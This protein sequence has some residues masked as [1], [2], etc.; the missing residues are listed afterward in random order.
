MSLNYFKVHS[1]FLT[2]YL[3]LVLGSYRFLVN[4]YRNVVLYVASYSLQIK[5]EKAE[6]ERDEHG[7]GESLE[8]RSVIS[9]VSQEKTQGG[10]P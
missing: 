8:I 3:H 10:K 6:E 4:P 7:K 1:H 2:C 5:T 9:R